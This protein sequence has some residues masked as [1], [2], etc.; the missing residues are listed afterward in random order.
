MKTE[1]SVVV[2]IGTFMLLHHGPAAVTK[3]NASQFQRRERSRRARRFGKCRQAL[4]HVLGVRNF[5]SFWRDKLAFNKCIRLR[6][7]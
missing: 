1:K 7:V 6:V 5:N 2:C 3:S 4:K